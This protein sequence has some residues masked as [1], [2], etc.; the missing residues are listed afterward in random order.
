[1]ETRETKFLSS[2]NHDQF[3]ST[4][5][6]SSVSNQL[7]IV[8]FF[9]RTTFGGVQLL[10]TIS[11]YKIFTQSIEINSQSSEFVKFVLIGKVV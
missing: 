2:E 4:S 9:F 1:M 3:Y 11:F 5:W 10:E 7:P 8:C 6:L